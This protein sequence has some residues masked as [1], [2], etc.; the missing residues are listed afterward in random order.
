MSYLPL[1]V[2]DDLKGEPLGIETGEV[3]DDCITASSHADGTPPSSARLN[4]PLG[5]YAK[6]AE[7]SWLQ[8]DLGSLHCVT[9]VATQGNPTGNNDY[10]KKYKLQYSLD[11]ENW[12]YH[13]ENGNQVRF[14]FGGL[15]LPVVLAR[16]NYFFHLS[17]SFSF[18]S[19]LILYIFLCCE[20]E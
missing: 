9:S 14:N 7:K 6:E 18:P 2:P 4:H 10:V 16:V 1:S 11:G 15:G 8:V 20:I 19:L 5:W 17:S 3:Q 13:E 12:N